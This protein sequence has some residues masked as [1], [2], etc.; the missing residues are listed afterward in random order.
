MRF[1]VNFNTRSTVVQR[2]YERI[3]IRVFGYE[4]C[5]Y[6][7]LLSGTIILKRYSSLRELLWYSIAT[8][9]TLW[10]GTEFICKSWIQQLHCF[11]NKS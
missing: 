4:C 5:A 8:F 6:P 11:R 1:Y 2:I 10:H 7:L 3:S 9:L